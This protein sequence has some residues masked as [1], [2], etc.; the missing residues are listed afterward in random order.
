MS[1]NNQ[2]FRSLHVVV[3]G[4]NF[5]W[6]CALVDYTMGLFNTPANFKL[7]SLDFSNETPALEMRVLR[8]QVHQKLQRRVSCAIR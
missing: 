1:Q 7:A 2:S 4:Q 3:F 8:L 5:S 6:P